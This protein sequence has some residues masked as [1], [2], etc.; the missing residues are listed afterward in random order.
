MV[1]LEEHQTQFLKVVDLVDHMRVQVL[2]VTVNG[3]HL[4]LR[5]LKV[6]V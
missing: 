1:I 4:E 2:Q 5:L 6:V 3:Q